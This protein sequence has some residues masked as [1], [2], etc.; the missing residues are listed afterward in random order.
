MRPQRS[1][2]STAS[3]QSSAFAT[4]H[5]SAS[6]TVPMTI[7][8]HPD[9][10]HAAEALQQTQQT[11]SGAARGSSG[12]GLPDA[13]QL[14]GSH[15][16]RAYPASAPVIGGT[17][18]ATATAGQAA[19]SPIA[20]PFLPLRLEATGNRI[21][22]ADQEAASPVTPPS[23]RNYLDPRQA[24]LSSKQTAATPDLA[25]QLHPVSEPVKPYFTAA[26]SVR[27]TQPAGTAASLVDL[28]PSMARP[29]EPLLP[30][31]SGSVWA[32]GASSISSHAGVAAERT[33]L[34]GAAGA[35]A[36]HTQSASLSSEASE[37][38]ESP[39]SSSSKDLSY[40][41]VLAEAAKTISAMSMGESSIGFSP[42]SVSS[43]AASFPDTS[44]PLRRRGPIS[45]GRSAV[46]QS[47]GGAA[48][49]GA[50]HE[51][52]NPAERLGSLSH[53]QGF[54]RAGS[55]SFAGSHIAAEDCA[56]SDAASATGTAATHCSSTSG[57]PGL[58]DAKAAQPPRPPRTASTG[59]APH[60]PF[61]MLFW[62]K[63]FCC[64]TPCCTLQGWNA[65]ACHCGS[66]VTTRGSQ[67]HGSF[68]MSPVGMFLGFCCRWCCFARKPACC[69]C[70]SNCHETQG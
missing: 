18:T 14:V 63:Y 33:Q 39:K 41:A 48:S 42:A 17:N 68:L 23:F 61:T 29:A 15:S 45:I 52:G 59:T 70:G 12:G 31:Q 58:A 19:L 24:S 66:L 3:Q 1:V 50:D 35:A 21:T 6:G 56:Q 51:A 34:Q 60:L 54:D 67:T 53:S 27:A 47:S 10:M 28:S 62:H 22:K 26:G 46:R 13:A 38:R 64:A 65:P 44:S 36:N 20:G 2:L 32:M 5:A 9:E 16:D 49:L 30:N 37:L 25:A 69:V 8:E 40:S 55:V 11:T 57:A 43:D 4:S 7:L